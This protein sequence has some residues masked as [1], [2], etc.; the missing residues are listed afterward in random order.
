MLFKKQIADLKEKIFRS[1]RGEFWALTVINALCVL[2]LNHKKSTWPEIDN[3][4]GLQALGA[5]KVN[6]FYSS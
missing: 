3:L 2:A 4:S 1:Q 6:D 5:P